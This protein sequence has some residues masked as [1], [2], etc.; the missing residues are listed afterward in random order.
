MRLRLCDTARKNFQIQKIVQKAF[1]PNSYEQKMQIRLPGK[2]WMRLRTILVELL[3]EL[4]RDV[5]LAKWLY[6]ICTRTKFPL[7]L[8]QFFWNVLFDADTD[9]PFKQLFT[10][11]LIQIKK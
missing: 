7:N 6:C 9:V 2:I 5:A 1:N 10:D 11:I 8:L 3:L 4:Q